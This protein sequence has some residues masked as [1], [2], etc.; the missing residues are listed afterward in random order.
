[1]APLTAAVAVAGPPN[2][3]LSWS[4]VSRNGDVLLEALREHVVLTVGAMLT[5]LVVAIPLGIVAREYRRTEGPILAVAGTLYTIPS[6]ALIGAMV[7]IFGLGRLTVIVPLAVYALLVIVR[8][9][10]VGLDGVPEEVVDAARGMGFGRARQLLRVELP[11][12]LPA[13]LAGVRVATVSTVGLVTVGGYVGYG[14]FGNLIAL[15]FTRST[16]R[17]QVVTASLCAVALALV[18]DLALVALQRVL[19]P[20]ARRRGATA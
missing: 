12:A 9:L 13:V 2:P 19:T 5:A 8:N 17:A 3:W 6:L 16:G 1:V 4:W 10:V 15:G 20:W 7:P 11:L 14:G 18:A